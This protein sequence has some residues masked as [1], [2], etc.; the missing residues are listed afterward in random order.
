VAQRPQPG[1]LDLGRSLFAGNRAAVG[2]AE[3]G[4]TSI[5]CGI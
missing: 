1:P 4:A 3:E 5:S 2:S